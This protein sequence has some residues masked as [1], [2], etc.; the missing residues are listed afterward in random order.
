MSS[1]SVQKDELEASIRNLT[2]T[3][4][5]PLSPLLLSGEAMSTDDVKADQNSAELGQNI[6]ADQT[7]SASADDLKESQPVSDNTEEK[8]ANN[9]PKKKKG[10][11]LTIQIPQENKL[12]DKTPHPVFAELEELVAV[13]DSGEEL[14]WKEKARWIKFEEDVQEAADRW[15]KPHVA[16]LSFHSLLE[17]KRC[18]EVGTV[19]LDMKESDFGSIAISLVETPTRKSDSGSKGDISKT[20][21]YQDAPAS[22]AG[23]RD[24]PNSENVDSSQFV[25]LEMVS[26]TAEK[27]SSNDEQAQNPPQAEVFT[28]F[29]PMT[30]VSPS[31]QQAEKGVLSPSVAFLQESRDQIRANLGKS[32]TNLDKQE[33][34]EECDDSGILR[35]IPSGSEACTVL[36]GTVNDMKKPIVAF[37]RLTKGR[38]LGNLAEAPIPVRFIFIM[39]GPEDDT[40]NY[41]EIGRSISTLMSN[42]SFN[43]AAYAAETRMDL[44]NAINQFLDQSVVLPPGDWDKDMLDPVTLPDNSNRIG[45]TVRIL[46]DENELSPRFADVHMVGQEEN[47][48]LKRTGRLFGGFINECKKRYPYYVSDFKDGLN[49]Q[50]LAAF[51]FIYFACI[52]PAITFGGLISSKTDGW[53]GVSEMILGTAIIGLMFAFFA[54]QPLAIIGSTGPILI[55]EEI[56]YELCGQF[57]IEY[58]VFRFWIGAWVMIICFVTVALEGSFLVRYFSRF[59]QEIF[60]ALVSIIFI[61]EAFFNLIKIYENHP[62]ISDYCTVVENNLSTTNAT[63]PISFFNSNISNTTSAVQVIPPRPNTSLLSTILMLGT[64]GL[65]MFFRQFRNSQYLGRQARQIISD[66]GIPISIAAMV[67]VNLLIHGVYVRTLEVPGG[68]STTS[69]HKR[70][71]LINP[72]GLKE[73]FPVGLMFLAAV[74]AL[75]VLILLFMETEIT[76]LLVNKKENKMKKGSGFHINLLL[77]GIGV[78]ITSLIGAPW[79][80]V[81][82]VRTLSHTLSVTVMSKSNAPGEKSQLVEVKEQRVSNLLIHIMIGAS[83]FLTDVLRL[84]PI[85]VLYGVFLYMGF[86]SLNGVQLIERIKML[87]MP[88]KYH[89]ETIFVRNVPTRKI[90]LFTLVQIVCIVVLWVIKSTDASIAF[91]LFIILTIPV[92]WQ[93]KH[94]FTR[95]ELI[96]LDNDGKTPLPD[97]EEDEVEVKSPD[98][99]A[100]HKD[101]TETSVKSAASPV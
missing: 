37:A 10:P 40:I 71:W 89:P 65:A 69:P 81:A 2:T 41:Y 17:L 12:I 11:S 23:V 63:I 91:P 73:P 18:L 93:M 82:T 64:F 33:E 45:S 76:L 96:A 39:M 99:G 9:E 7:T 92:R 26:D 62:L 53:I 66:F 94:F 35:K 80:C 38:R 14:A 97:D 54:G 31:M 61:Y 3:A 70:G 67:V 47:D 42:E 55:F 90:H 46:A 88:S 28:P 50:T 78:G 16:Y 25:S 60:S 75:L 85:P 57:N 74:P 6:N 20:E 79:M 48:P 49:F 29:V 27:A 58:I 95:R 24:V 72:L 15:G 13:D 77:V 98:F 8:E 4:E 51:I 32:V 1:L 19:M 86:T 44:L 84:I 34:I 5:I 43:Q 87:I 83:L 21:L 68:L 100:G 36:V 56:V 101:G 59:T 22:G 30:P 52:S